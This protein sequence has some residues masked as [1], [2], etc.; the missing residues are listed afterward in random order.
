MVN[1]QKST[2]A[3]QVAAVLLTV[4]LPVGVT[5]C[6]GGSKRDAAP[7]GQTATSGGENKLDEVLLGPNPPNPPQLS[8]PVQDATVQVGGMKRTYLS[9]IPK[10]LPKNAPLLIVYHGSDMTAAD[11][12]VFTGYEFE[13]LAD[14]NK[15]ALV[16][17]NGYQ[18]HWN[19]CRKSGQYAARKD[20]VDDVGFTKAIIDRFRQSNGIN[21]VFNMGYSNGGDL[22]YRLLA[23]M[24][25]QIKA[26]AP[27]AANL[28]A[29]DNDACPP[30]RQPTPALMITGT[31]DPIDPYN[32][33]AVSIGGQPAG[34]VLSSP[35]TAAQ[36]AKI[37]GD[38]AP[39]VEK[40]L[41]HSPAS[42]M[43]SVKV[44]TYATPGKPPVVEYTVVNG[45]HVVPN[46]MFQPPAQL[47]GLSTLDLNAPKAIWDFFSSPE[48]ATTN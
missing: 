12:R 31:K 43:T 42:G 7:V 41:P 15:F 38:T 32:G 3:R 48:K 14:A 26:I 11:M 4:A 35:A 36:L 29:P 19:D 28:P 27:V 34:N 46:P 5:A 20:N 33:G 24:P 30:M 45:G 8:A 2:I 22:Q 25:G 37:N 1:A 9:F 39:P 47:F 13:R 40:Q 44:K 23:E 18:R 10:D 16:Y 21:Q 17:P 6:S